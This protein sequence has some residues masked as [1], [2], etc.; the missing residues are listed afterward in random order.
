MTTYIGNP[1]KSVYG[2]K[3]ATN[4]IHDV[5]LTSD[6]TSYSFGDIFSEYGEE[7]FIIEVVGKYSGAGNSAYVHVNGDTTEANYK[8]VENYRD[9]TNPNNIINDGASGYIG[10]HDHAQYYTRRLEVTVVPDVDTGSGYLVH[11]SSMF[12]AIEITGT[13]GTLVNTAVMYNVNVSSL[14]DLRYSINGTDEMLA[15]TRLKVWTMQAKNLILPLEYSAPRKNYI[16]N[17]DFK[18]NQ[19]AFAGGTVAAGTYTFDRWKNFGA[20]VTLPDTDGFV[21]VSAGN[22]GDFQQVLEEDTFPE[23]T[24]VTVSWE[25]TVLASDYNSEGDAWQNFRTSPFTFNTVIG[26]VVANS[27][28][29]IGFTA[30]T[31][32]NL[33]LELGEVATP[34][35]YP[36]IATELVKCQRYYQVITFKDYSNLGSARANNAN[37]LIGNIVPFLNTMRETPDSAFNPVLTNLQARKTSNF[38]LISSCTLTIQTMSETS[39]TLKFTKTA[40]F[41]GGYTYNVNMLSGNTDLHLDAEL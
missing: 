12:R 4:L 9:S 24:Q 2:I 14:T 27:L 18:I 19:R 32:K 31:L 25:G 17:P 41:T 6:A 23:G 36:D 11:I 30:G 10:W 16:I 21:T 15:G 37:D 13:D 5:E 40:A 22:D 8:S 39:I 1:P 34:F 3:D 28:A 20:S 33:K 29:V 35:D 26:T 38:A 7:T